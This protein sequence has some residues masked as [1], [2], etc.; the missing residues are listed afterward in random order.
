MEEL[1]KLLQELEQME[2]RESVFDPL[3]ENPLEIDK[4][5]VPAEECKEFVFRDLDKQPKAGDMYDVFLNLSNT[6][7]YSVFLED[8]YKKTDFLVDADIT[9]TNLHASEVIVQ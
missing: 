8:G 1:G 5:E 9:D 7:F 2:T 4:K 3:V 6:I